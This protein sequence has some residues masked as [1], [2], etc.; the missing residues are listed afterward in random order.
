VAASCKLTSL[1]LLSAATEE[2]DHEAI[3]AF[4]YEVK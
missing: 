3:S 2:F 1:G 4:H